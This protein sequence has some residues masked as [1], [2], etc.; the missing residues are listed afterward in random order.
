MTT[1]VC[2][3]VPGLPG[4]IL[5]GTVRDHGTVTFTVCHGRG[6]AVVLDLAGQ[7]FDR[8]VITVSDPGE[9]VSRLT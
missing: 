6:P 3:P 9:I 1:A 2:G 4:V 8:I 7:P 5:A